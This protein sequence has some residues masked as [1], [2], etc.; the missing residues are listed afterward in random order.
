MS[1]VDTKRP[2]YDLRRYQ[3]HAV[4]ATEAAWRGERRPTGTGVVNRAAS[5]MA[6]GLGK[7]II[8]SELVR[9]AHERGERGIFLVHREELAEQAMAKMHSI[10]PGASIG[11][12]K[13]ERDE[14]DADVVVASVP[15][16]GRSAKRRERI[17]ADRFGIGI[18]DECHHAAA[19]T[20]QRTIGYFGGFNGMPWA[21]F[22]ATMARGDDKVLGETWTEVVA[23]KDI[24]WG[25]REGYLVP[26]SGKRIRV[27]DLLLDEVKRSRGDYQ[28]DDLGAA[29]ED[30]DAGTAIAV[31]YLKHCTADGTG[32]TGR[33]AAMFSPTK[34]TARRFADDLNEAGIPTEV[35]LGETTTAERQAIYERFRL[36]ITKVISSCMV[37]T[38]GWDA[39]WAE[40]A[41]M[42]RP[43]SAQALYIQCIGRVLRPFKAGG[44]TSALVLD[45]VGASEKNKIM[46]LVE[47]WPNPKEMPPYDEF[48][49]GDEDEEIL[50][51]PAGAE[52]REWHGTADDLHVAEVDLFDTSDSVWLQT[53]AGVWF[54]PTREH[55][56][57]LWPTANGTFGLGKKPIAGRQG[58]HGVVLE[59]GLTLEGGMAWAER[60]A[61][62]ED[63]S[64]SN[65]KAYWRKK[66][67]SDA[68]IR[69][70]RSLRIPAALEPVVTVNQ[71]ALSDQITTAK[72]SLSLPIPAIHV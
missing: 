3:R 49:D 41:I 38:E 63:R 44:K 58:A 14:W 34:R 40:V 62:D 56:Y 25:I 69:L 67:P 36:G 64:I 19:E 43:T 46:S 52:E 5:V 20:W 2:V 32:A 6:T 22:T 71:G 7:T 12:V 31:A 35:V 70:G 23:E 37:I 59:K 17:P 54:V 15:T 16:L 50:G 26:V 30:A 29:M 60:Y 9:R 8:E 72:A 45:V 27:K 1:P 48:P 68:M 33:R 42:A 4:E 39:P 18:A 55:Y 66:S 24:A 11:L 10:I 65:R 28:D 47:L 53:A 51:G 13:A 57:Y 21:G 61:E